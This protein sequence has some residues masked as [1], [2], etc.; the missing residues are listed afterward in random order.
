MRAPV[1]RVGGA[2]KHG[3]NLGARNNIIQVFG[4]RRWL[5]CLPIYTRYGIACMQVEFID[6]N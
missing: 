5:W 3:F 4:K 6:D 2:D 1:F